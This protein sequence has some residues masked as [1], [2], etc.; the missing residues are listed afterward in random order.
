MRAAR[1]FVSLLVFLSMRVFGAPPNPANV[2]DVTPE[3]AEKLLKENP[4]TLV[5]DV[6]TAGEFKAGHI[7]GAKNVDFFDDNFAK[8]VAALDSAT[9]II[10]HCAAGG[11]SAQSLPFL[12]D[13]KVVYHLKDGFRAWEKAG[14]P[15]EK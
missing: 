2:T 15:V 4:K 3:Q 10:V 1:I 12:K 14:K 8:Q 13:K 5:L 11:R 9:P 6:R 7:P